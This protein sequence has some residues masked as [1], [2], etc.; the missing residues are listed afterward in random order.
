MAIPLVNAATS[1]RH[2]SPVRDTVRI[3][4]PRTI[5]ARQLMN[6]TFEASCRSL[7][8]PNAPVLVVDLDGT[9]IKTDLLVETALDLLKRSPVFLFLFPVWLARGKANLKAEIAKRVQI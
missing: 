3:C 4:A 8:E 9:L 7:V 6:N 5:S 1:P 2:S